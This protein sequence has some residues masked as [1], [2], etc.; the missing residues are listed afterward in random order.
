MTRSE[1]V[2][3]PLA[4]FGT[5]TPQ[6]TLGRPYL[7]GSGVSVR[8]PSWD[9]PPCPSASESDQCPLWGRRARDP[10]FVSGYR[11]SPCVPHAAC[12]GTSLS[13]TRRWL[14]TWG[15]LDLHALCHCMMV[16][17]TRLPLAPSPSVPSPTSQSLSL[18]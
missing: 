1:D 9:P 14:Q 7:P 8:L 17:A 13:A 4:S 3:S 16:G 2:W 15:L 10:P 12:P 18:M 11:A 6:R 5:R